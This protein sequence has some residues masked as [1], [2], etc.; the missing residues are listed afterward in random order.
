MKL[1]ATITVMLLAVVAIGS[2]ARG[3]AE[4]FKY[5]LPTWSNWKAYSPYP[6]NY[7]NR[8]SMLQGWN[9]E[10]GDGLNC[11]GFISNARGVKFHSSYD[12][13]LNRFNDLELVAEVGGVSAI[14]EA[15]LQPGDIAAFEGPY[16]SQGVHGVH[17]AAYLGNGMWVDSDFRRESITTYRMSTKFRQDR[18]FFGHVRLYRWKNSVTFSPVAIYSSLGREDKAE[19]R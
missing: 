4:A 13:Y 18:W 19:D 14:N 5:Q 3:F 11:S 9:T 1:K 10:K 15:M 17:V 2:Q 16:A 7:V 12:F 6:F 8:L